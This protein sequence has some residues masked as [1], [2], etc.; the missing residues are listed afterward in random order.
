[1]SSKRVTR[2]EALR[3]AEAK[4]AAVKRTRTSPAK[5]ARGRAAD[6]EA[7]AQRLA[8][9]ARQK[10][11]TDTANKAAADKAAA[12]EKEAQAK[13]LLKLAADA[14]AS[15]AKASK[16]SAQ[17]IDKEEKA[18]LKADKQA[19]KLADAK[20]KAEKKAEK[21]AEK[22][23]AADKKAAK[24]A[25]KALKK[26][27]PNDSPQPGQK[28]SAHEWAMLM[29]HTKPFWNVK[30]HKQPSGIDLGQ[31]IVDHAHKH[32]DLVTRSN[33]KGFDN[34]L[35]GS[36]TLW[37]N[38]KDKQLKL[39][40]ERAV[41]R[42]FKPPSGGGD[43]SQEEEDYTKAMQIY[44]QALDEAMADAM[45]GIIPGGPPEWAQWV[46][47]Y[48]D[49]PLAGALEGD[50][51]EASKEKLAS[52]KRKRAASTKSSRKKAKAVDSE[53]DADEKLVTVL[54]ALS[55]TLTAS[56]PLAGT[57]AAPPVPVASAV[58]PQVSDTVK[59]L[60]DQMLARGAFVSSSNLDLGHLLDA[61]FE[62]M[63][64]QVAKSVGGV[65][66]DQFIFSL[67]DFAALAYVQL[68]ALITHA[69]AR[70]RL[71]P[72]LL[73]VQVTMHTGPVHVLAQPPLSFA[74]VAHAARIA[75]A[76]SVLP[77]PLPLPAALAPA[78]LPPPLPA[79]AIHAAAD[80]GLVA[81]DVWNCE[82]CTYT[83]SALLSTCEICEKRRSYVLTDEDSEEA[84][85]APKLP[86]WQSNSDDATEVDEAWHFE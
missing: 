50:A 37:K 70:N 82:H 46:D 34:K 55:A 52:A 38:A 68:A 11:I 56:A 73:Y 33:P 2:E 19:A 36:R 49:A 22:K 27:K 58:A 28:W 62:G 17:K 75:S 83:N 21:D 30:E 40:V 43:S 85:Q 18:K 57:P 3:I 32:G 66:Q 20:L 48:G 1:M 51:Y 9:H 60:V 42:P 80:R 4:A 86:D 26:E 8:K 12:A 14:K 24:L 53:D 77:P 72:I 81:E 61:I 35:R 71:H 67:A 16:V 76:A 45:E 84:P 44:Q 69:G 78:A 65:F 54:S 64:P 5:S 10:Q 23:A 13:K 29:K 39:L 6:T 25:E 63:P 41:Q 79:Q 15:E 47:L 59:S 74:A 31:L 7:K